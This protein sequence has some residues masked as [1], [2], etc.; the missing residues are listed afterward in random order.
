MQDGNFDIS[1]SKKKIASRGQS[2][3]LDARPGAFPV[4]RLTGH[5]ARMLDFL[6]PGQSKSAEGHSFTAGALEAAVFDSA[7]YAD[8]IHEG[9]GSSAKF[10]ERPFLTDA[11]ESFN[12][13]DKIKQIIED[14]IND[15]MRGSGL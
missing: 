5:L 3:S 10:G 1:R 7:E 6:D 15:A 2:S 8:I 13:G 9:R 14:K 4:P 11:L 12:R